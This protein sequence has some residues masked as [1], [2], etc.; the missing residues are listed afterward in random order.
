MVKKKR[1]IVPSCDSYL[2]K[3]MFS[4]PKE[5]SKKKLWLEAINL[6]SH[7]PYDV[8]CIKHFREK[9]DYCK[10]PYG[11]GSGFKY[12][13]A[14]DA[15]PNLFLPEK[16]KVVNSNEEIGQNFGENIQDCQNKSEQTPL[17]NIKNE[18]VDEIQG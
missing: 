17:I 18:S 7:G 16:L 4:F 3:G 10:S 2:E 6:D 12:K 8:V 13:L 9:Y 15:V 5:D 11:N 14:E 1:C